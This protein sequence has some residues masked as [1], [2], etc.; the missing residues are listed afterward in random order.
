MLVA[1]VKEFSD[2]GS[3]LIGSMIFDANPS[4]G[5]MICALTTTFVYALIVPVI[6]F[7]P[8]EI[9]QEQGGKS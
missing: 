9:I 4:N 6:K 7:I 5:L 3:D 8:D 2:R 1:G